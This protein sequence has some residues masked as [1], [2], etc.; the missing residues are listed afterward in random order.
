MNAWNRPKCQARRKVWRLVTLQSWSPAPMATA[1]A[2]MARP[3]AM[4]RS[5][6]VDTGRPAQKVGAGEAGAEVDA[7]GLGEG[8]GDGVGSGLGMRYRFS[9]PMVLSERMLWNLTRPGS[10][11]WKMSKKSRSREARLRR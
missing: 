8:D 1:K 3:R 2:S 11:R 9:S 6:R 10:T 5:V 4:P 7:D